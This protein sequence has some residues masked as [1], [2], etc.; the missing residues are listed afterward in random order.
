[1]AGVGARLDRA[2]RAYRDLEIETFQ[3]DA[4]A[5]RTGL[6]CLDE[7][8]DAVTAA[9]IHR[10]FGVLAFGERDQELALLSFEAAHRAAPAMGLS[11]LL[12]PDG[13]PMTALYAAATTQALEIEP[14][15][16]PR[17]GVVTFDGIAEGRPQGIPTVFQ[18][19]T[20]GAAE[21]ALL[22]ATE[23]TPVFDVTAPVVES[24][25]QRAPRV[26]NRAALVPLAVGAGA[27]AVATGVLYGL[28]SS[29]RADYFEADTREEM[30][31]LRARTNTFAISSTVTGT[32]AVGAGLGALVVGSW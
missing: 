6:A 2:E 15:A 9:R 5:L 3:A 30:E 21:T 1:V 27:S 31:T 32:L 17:E 12:V 22:A 26:R 20:S 23:A 13:H 19:T 16:E 11:E 25:L 24:T 4:A 28:G 14:V 10:L 18:H 8:L 7:P 29:A